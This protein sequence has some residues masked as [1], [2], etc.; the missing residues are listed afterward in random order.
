[1]L[2][3]GK[4][5]D[6]PS[7]S[8][9]A[10]NFELL[11]SR[12]LLPLDLKRCQPHSVIVL[13]KQKPDISSAKTTP[14]QTVLPTGLHRVAG[15]VSH[16]LHRKSIPELSDQHKS[17]YTVEKAQGMGATVSSN[18]AIHAQRKHVKVSSSAVGD[19]HVTIS[20]PKYGTSTS[21]RTMFDS[22]S[23]TLSKTTETSRHSLY[24]SNK[25]QSSRKRMWNEGASDDDDEFDKLCNMVNLSFDADVT[26]DLVAE[27]TTSDNSRSG[28]QSVCH[29]GNTTAGLPR[30]SWTCPM[31]NEQFEG[32]LALP[33]T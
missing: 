17:N 1:M 19:H 20:S 10:P 4:A 6:T 5:E 2:S 11:T 24:G 21:H 28:S 22:K 32:R 3:D 12:V 13:D 31:C 9:P 33:C 25:V 14:H 7:F 16:D 15:P 26:S 23:A 30:Q 18:D 27:V 8:L 29:V